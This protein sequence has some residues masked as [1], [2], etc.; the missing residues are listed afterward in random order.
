ML[1]GIDAY[2]NHYHRMGT[3]IDQYYMI[4]SSKEFD[5]TYPLNSNTNFSLDLPSTLILDKRWEVAVTELWF[6]NITNRG[7]MDLCADFCSETLVNGKFIPLLRRVEMKKG[8]NHITYT[9]PNYFNI[10]RS[11][12][13]H[14]NFFITHT[15]G[16]STSFLREELTLKVHFRKRLT[17]L[18]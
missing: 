4:L 8:Y 11:E 1:L 18:F 7:Q 9:T 12:L 13:K 15:S 3:E 6:R 2:T 17:G 14:L 10:S 5:H 16:E